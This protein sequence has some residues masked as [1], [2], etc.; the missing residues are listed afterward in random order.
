MK[1]H[2]V[3]KKRIIIS[4]VIISIFACALIW[5]DKAKSIENSSIFIS[6]GTNFKVDII[7]KGQSD[8]C[9]KLK[10]LAQDTE[11]ELKSGNVEKI[12]LDECEEIMIASDGAF[13][14]RIGEL[15][16]LWDI[17]GP[18][19][20]WTP[21]SEEEI[22]NALKSASDVATG[23]QSDAY[24]FGAVGKGLYLDRAA[25]V[26]KQ[27][28]AGSGVISAGGSIL[29]Y[30]RKA[31]GS[32]WN[33][34]IVDP[35]VGLN[36]N[37]GAAGNAGSGEGAYAGSG[38]STYGKIRITHTDKQDTTYISTS[39]SYERYK[40]YNGMRY[41]HILDPRTGYPSDS[42]LVSVTIISHDSGFITD[43]LSTAVFVLG[44]EE[45]V[46][47]CEK[48]DVS[49]ILIRNDGSEVTAG[50]LKKDGDTWTYKPLQ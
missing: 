32:D 40:E 23:T 31:D 14:V 48:Y 43:A 36:G 10:V 29:V 34:A 6:M 37:S 20:G 5:A 47:L 44:E 11:A 7:S 16:N 25:D 4:V 49:A 12:L 46:K 1:D 21:P 19:E 38:S 45:G 33:V 9:D 35:F 41:H 27:N 13:D 39:G 24:D 30:G 26:L 18:N 3:D 28:K 50:D 8:I 15:I 42:G 2:R 22:G 17:N